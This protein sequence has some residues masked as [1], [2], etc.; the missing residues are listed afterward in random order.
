MKRHRMPI[1]RCLIIA[2]LLCCGMGWGVAVA[3]PATTRPA[4]PIA[5]LANPA[6][7]ESSGVAVSRAHPGVLWTHNDS[8][9]SPRFFATNEKG[10]D[11]GT[12]N[13][14][15]ARA[16]DWEDMASY[17]LDGKNFLVLGDIGD[18]FSILPE[19]TL[20]F[21]PEPA[22]PDKPKN[23]VDVPI[24]ARV[25]FTYEDG[26]RNCESVAVDPAQRVVLLVSKTPKGTNE[27]KAYLLPLPREGKAKPAIARAIATLKIPTTTGADISPDGLRLI[28]TTYDDAY[29]YTREASEQWASALTREPR[30]VKLPARAQGESICYGPDGKTLYLTSEGRPCPLFKVAR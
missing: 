8:G 26:A 20:Y 3:Q 24:W 19:R 17:S 14:Q 18:N 29:E 5:M 1:L 23:P 25:D 16:L 4:G 9:D 15:G 2:T 21:V 7:K 28:I 22:L 12:F 10:E 6:I 11:L 27:C 13:V 30:G